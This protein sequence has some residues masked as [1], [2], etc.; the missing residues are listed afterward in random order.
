M[1]AFKQT[2]ITFIPP[3]AYLTLLDRYLI[4][5]FCIVVLVAIQGPVVAYRTFVPPQHQVSVDIWTSFALGLVAV[6]GHVYF[7]FVAIRFRNLRNRALG[8]V[9]VPTVQDTSKLA[10]ILGEAP[11]TSDHSHALLDEQETPQ[12]QKR[13]TSHTIHHEGSVRKL[14]IIPDSLSTRN[15]NSA[16][17]RLVGSGAIRL[18]AVGSRV[19]GHAAASWYDSLPSKG[20][21]MDHLTHVKLKREHV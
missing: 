8:Q 2:V 15:S 11:I 21:I 20:W 4:L 13:F 9:F 16:R 5:C 12:L 6:L 17:V 19:R 7:A 10:W 3:V 1:V 14:S 18:D